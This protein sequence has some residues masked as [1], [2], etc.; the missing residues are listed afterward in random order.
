MHYLSIPTLHTKSKTASTE[1]T[2]TALGMMFLLW[3]VVLQVTA[4]TIYG[5]NCY[6]NHRNIA[7]RTTNSK[8]LQ[9]TQIYYW[10]KSENWVGF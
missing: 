10:V 8:D 9:N 2:N 3:S 4:V 7:A 1:R 5:V 6:Q